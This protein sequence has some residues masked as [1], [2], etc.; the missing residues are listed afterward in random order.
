MMNTRKHITN[1]IFCGKRIEDGEIQNAYDY[2]LHEATRGDCCSECDALIVSTN[3]LL[4]TYID[5]K[6]VWYIDLAVDQMRNAKEKIK[7]EKGYA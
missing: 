4:K 3:R 7:R 1:C 6:N 2:G 5:T